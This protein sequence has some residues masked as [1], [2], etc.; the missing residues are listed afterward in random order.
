MSAAISSRCSAAR[1]P[2][3]RSR[4]ARKPTR[5]CAFRLMRNWW[6]PVLAADTESP[7]DAAQGSNAIGRFCL[8]ADGWFQ[9]VMAVTKMR[10]CK[11]DKL[12]R[13]K[14]KPRTVG[15]A[16]LSIFRGNGRPEQRETELARDR[17]DRR[18]IE[19]QLA[20]VLPS[21]LHLS[22]FGQRGHVGNG[23][24]NRAQHAA[25]GCGQCFRQFLCEISGR[26]RRR[27]GR[28]RGTPP[29]SS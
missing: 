3:G 4:R 6:L 17:L 20:G 7:G 16:G 15:G 14:E 18:T 13:I 23:I 9:V 28:I 26:Q 5:N 2:R 1:L 11:A 10:F 8:S 12:E 19:D 24:A 29:V 22:G 21:L 27:H 25:V